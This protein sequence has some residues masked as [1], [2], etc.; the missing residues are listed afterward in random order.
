MFSP[1]KVYLLRIWSEERRDS[2]AWRFRLENP[3]SGEHWS[4]PSHEAFQR[5]LAEQLAAG[6]DP[7]R[8]PKP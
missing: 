1:S 3:H 4:F 7:T 8:P 2:Q 6:S 5:F